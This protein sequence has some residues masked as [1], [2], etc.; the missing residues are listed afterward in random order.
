MKTSNKLIGEIVKMREYHFILNSLDENTNKEIMFYKFNALNNNDAIR[1]LREL[2]TSYAYGILCELAHTGSRNI[3][4]VKNG[5]EISAEDLINL[6]KV[7]IS[8]HS[9]GLAASS[10]GFKNI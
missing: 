4:S 5:T 2:G 8:G 7:A 3:E 10:L 1:H 9:N 6:D